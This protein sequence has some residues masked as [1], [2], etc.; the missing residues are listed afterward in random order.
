MLSSIGFNACVDQGSSDGS[1]T[2]GE[3][4]QALERY[5]YRFDIVGKLGS[6]RRGKG[7][8]HLATALE[9]LLDPAQVITNLLCM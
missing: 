5:N 2:G 7:T 8:K 3:E 4:A 1:F 6:G 9:E